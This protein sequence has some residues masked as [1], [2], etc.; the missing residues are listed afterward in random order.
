MKY[1]L[2]R[3]EDHLQR[4]VKGSGKNDKMMEIFLHFQ[5]KLVTPF[6]IKYAGLEWP[7][8]V[9]NLRDTLQK[10]SLDA[11]AITEHDEIAWLFN[12]RGQGEST[13]EGLMHSPLFESLALVSDDQ[14]FLWIDTQKVVPGLMVHLNPREQR[15]L[16]STGP[17][18]KAR[19]LENHISLAL[20]RLDPLFDSSGSIGYDFLE[21]DV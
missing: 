13:N 14:V 16:G 7:Q 9:Q 3:T 2:K 17:L 20:A 5:G 10:L 21:R 19:N 1:G 18:L 11:M 12:L 6:S 4:Y 8:K 15:D